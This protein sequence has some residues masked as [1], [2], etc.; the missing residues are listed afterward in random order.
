[1]ATK[2]WVNNGSDKCLLPEKSKPLSETILAFYMSF[3][4]E[5]IEFEIIFIPM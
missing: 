5:Y 2:L 4:I 3:L 1:M